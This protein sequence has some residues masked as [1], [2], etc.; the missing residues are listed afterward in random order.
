MKRIVSF[1]LD[2][3]LLDHSTF[4]I[5]DSAMEALDRLREKCYVVLATGRDMDNHYSVQYRDIVRPDAIVHNNGTRITV[6]SETIY[7]SVMESELV[8]RILDFSVKEK[9]SVGVTVGND[10]YYTIPEFV[11]ANDLRRWGECGRQYRDPYTLLTMEVRTMTYIGPPEGAARIGEAFPE[12][13]LPLFAGLQGADIIERKN[14]KANGLR[15]LCSYWG[16]ERKDT[17]AFGDSMND[18]EILQ[19]AGIGI[20]MGNA[21]EELKRIAD[22]VTDSIEHDGVYKACVHFGLI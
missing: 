13:K 16:A 7:E 21:V 20:A 5:P 12:L 10:D 17:I 8:K 2:M 15:I 3:T 4:R 18:Y 14:S 22:Y 6:G 11:T 1:D 19:E 9:L